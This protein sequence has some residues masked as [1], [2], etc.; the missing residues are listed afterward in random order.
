[1]RQYKKFVLWIL[2][3]CIVNIPFF[4][5]IHADGVREG[6]YAAEV[7]SASSSEEFVSLDYKNAD[8]ATVLRSLSYSYDLNLV[9]TKDI[10][11]EVTVSLRGVTIDEALDAIL[12]VNGYIFTRKGNLIYITQGPALENMDMVT[13]TIRVKYLT[14]SEAS[15][16]LEKTIS[17]KGDIRVNE[18]TNSLVVTDYPSFIERA[19]KVL[20]EIDQL[21]VQVL[22]EAKLVDITET[23]L[24]NFGFSYT[25]DMQPESTRRYAGSQTLQGPSAEL[26]GGQLQLTA[27]KF[28]DFADATVTLDALVQKNKAHILASPSIATL[29][30]QE[31]RIVIGERYPYKEKTQTTTGTTETTKFV[32]IGTTLRVTPRVSP[33]GWITMVVHP[34]V[35]S[36]SEALDDGPRITTREADA[37][38]RVR[39][40]ETIVIGGLIKREDDKTKGKIPGLS[41]IPILG[42]FFRNMSRD[43]TAT[44]LVVFI[45]PR[46][47]KTPSELKVARA[48]G[49]KAVYVD[50]EGAGERV[51]VHRLWLEASDLENNEGVVSR[52]KDD[53][54]RMASAL[55][56]YQ[57]IV[58]QFPES[59]M[60][61]DALYR[62]GL[63]AY[64][65]FSDYGLAKKYFLQ[66][67]E[68]YPESPFAG[69]SKRKIKKIEREMARL[70]RK[71][72][73]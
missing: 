66:L 35:S 55:D 19:K 56:A 39:D 3:L 62:C 67:V 44:E 73:R 52:A 36:L 46:I 12:S 40:G 43:V 37:N 10:K 11:G 34:E 70:E 38:I 68:N 64:K 4:Y 2:C 9:A 32:D 28:K 26:T 63:I 1:M 49:E 65:Y 33:D 45:T 18:T 58:L 16:L 71:K 53:D 72:S 69:K 50:I 59:A 17:S 41:N 47:I 14:A 31:A 5:G 20:V 22:I 54:T 6:P 51:L 48:G 23:D 57:Q 60:A 8:L 24:K 42:W 61:D 27:F 30:G 25:I 7:S 29:N 15:E 21:P 13:E